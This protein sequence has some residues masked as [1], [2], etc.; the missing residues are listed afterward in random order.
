MTDD[1]AKLRHH[2]KLGIPLLMDFIKATPKTAA[3]L[4]E[5]ES[6]WA[7]DL[8][9]LV[10]PFGDGV[11]ARFEPLSPMRANELSMVAHCAPLDDAA[12]EARYCHAVRMS[13]LDELFKQ[14]PPVLPKRPGRKR[15]QGVFDDSAAIAAARKML[16]GPNP[17]SIRRAAIE[18]ADLAAKGLSKEADIARVYKA[19]RGTRFN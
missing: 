6:A 15:G 2:R 14:F 18:V 1:V 8:I 12:Q 7:R 17:P 11:A 19:L 3:G 9:P 13:R 10:E 5:R 16:A 4:V